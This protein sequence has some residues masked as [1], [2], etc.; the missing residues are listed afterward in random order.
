MRSPSMAAK[1]RLATP[2]QITT[3]STRRTSV[4]SPPVA[5]RHAT[6]MPS[7]SCR[8]AVTPYLAVD[9]IAGLVALAQAG[10]AE[11]HPWGA[12]TSKIETPDR[13]IFDL[14]P[15]E[16]LPFAEVVRAAQ[17]LRRRL[18]DLGLVPFCKT[19]G[20]KG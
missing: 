4:P 6:A 11:I 8:I 3:A 15:A 13:L 1:R 18:E 5:G 12:P 14:D 7:R 20:G 10:V 9:S 17:A 2:A 16:G 19:T